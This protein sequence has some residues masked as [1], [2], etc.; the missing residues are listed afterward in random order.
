MIELKVKHAK[1]WGV[2][3][4]GCL[5]MQ[6]IGCQAKND[7]PQSPAPAARS[8]SLAV[9]PAIN[10]S[11]SFDFDPISLGDLMASELTQLGGVR[12]VGVNRVLAMMAELGLAELQ[13]PEEV[14]ELADRLGTDGVLV[15][16]IT[17]YDPY[18]PPVVGMSAQVFLTER[19]F[20]ADTF[21]PLTT[22][23]L[24]ASRPWSKT[25]SGSGPQAEVQRVFNGADDATASQ[26]KYFAKYREAERSP[27]SWRKYLASQQHF[28]RFCCY[29]VA[30]ELVK[31][32]QYASSLAGRVPEAQEERIP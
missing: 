19:A 22:S 5:C 27:L 2:F 20:D 12:V 13:S 8:I 4:S 32:V 10:L 15:F 16:A 30:R 23:R 21:D 9:G 18:D 1:L 28:F 29:S 7:A 11:G 24:A 31:K 14:S 25:P 6:A 3:A 17:E 26:I